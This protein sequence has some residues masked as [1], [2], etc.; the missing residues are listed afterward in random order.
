MTD[1]VHAHAERARDTSITDF[2]FVMLPDGVLTDRSGRRYLTYGR[3]GH[4]TKGGTPP[5][6]LGAVHAMRGRSE[7]SSTS[8]GRAVYIITRHD[9]RK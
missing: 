8:L 2:K 9:S 6:R 7:F 5:R 4:V 1:D 3:S